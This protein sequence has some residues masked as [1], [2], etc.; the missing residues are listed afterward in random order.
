MTTYIQLI[1]EMNKL[2]YIFYVLIVFITISSKTTA[3]DV[4]RVWTIEREPF[5]HLEDS[6]EWSWFSIDLWKNIAKENDLQY[7]FVPYTDFGEML[8]DTEN[9]KNNLSVANISITA[10]RERV[11]DFSSPIYDSGLTIGEL[12]NNS[13]IFLFY[14]KY[15]HYLILWL[16]IFWWVLFLLS[17]YFFISNVLWGNIYLLSYPREIFIICMEILSQIKEVFWMK[18]IFSTTLIAWIFIIALISQKFTFALNDIDERQ[19]DPR[20]TISYKDLTASQVWT[21][22]G[23]VGEVFLEKKWIAVQS[24]TQLP[25]IYNDLITS[26]L[27]Y[28]VTDEPI[29]RYKAKN[30]PRFRVTWKSFN[31]DK[32][33]FLFPEYQNQENAPLI[34]KVNISLLQMRESGVYDDIYNTY[35]Q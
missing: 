32:Y 10:E 5:S 27:D 26:D 22:N 17:H 18:I 16:Q 19:L 31:K 13:E 33:A 25:D 34:K 35:F 11:L 3:A 28:I 23:S 4:L 7:E 9:K 20:S 1:F 30:D 24:Y 6:W 14:S 8:A 15:S 2:L 21:T 12:S 29:L